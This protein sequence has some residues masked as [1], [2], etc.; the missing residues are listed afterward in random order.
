VYSGHDERE[1]IRV[2]RKQEHVKKRVRGQKKSVSDCFFQQHKKRIL[3]LSQIGQIFLFMS[4]SAQMKSKISFL[5]GIADEAAA[6]K[7]VN[8][9]MHS[10]HCIQDVRGRMFLLSSQINEN[11]SSECV[12]DVLHKIL[13]LTTDLKTAEEQPPSQPAVWIASAPGFVPV[14]PVYVMMP[15][16]MQCANKER[17]VVTAYPVDRARTPPAQFFTDEEG[18][19]CDTLLSM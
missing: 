19:A 4:I 16:T 15:P 7:A 1:G 10:F 17:H 13:T 5:V 2:E 8:G 9:D 18:Q 11:A 14:S 6:N 12:N 3:A